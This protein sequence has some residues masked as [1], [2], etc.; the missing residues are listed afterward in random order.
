M[1]VHIVGPDLFRPKGQGYGKAAAEGLN[2]PPAPAALPDGCDMGN[3]P[4]LAAGPFQRRPETCLLL[5]ITLPLNHVIDSFAT[6]FILRGGPISLA[7]AQ[8]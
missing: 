2:E 1:G 7:P 4:A 3:Q 8:Q 5:G 6:L